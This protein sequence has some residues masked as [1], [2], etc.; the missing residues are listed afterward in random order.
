MLQPLLSLNT[1]IN[2]G[3]LGSVGLPSEL[4]N[5]A[6]FPLDTQGLGSEGLL[7][8]EQGGGR[9]GGPTACCA[10]CTP[11]RSC[12][13]TVQD[14]KGVPVACGLCPPAV[15]ALV[16]SKM[17]NACTLSEQVCYTEPRDSSSTW[18]CRSLSDA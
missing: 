8:T 9:S 14:V 18:W 5:L 15:P 12:I 17:K 7:H 11:S 16:A 6:S 2:T 4:Q 3:S 1:L 13:V 10:S